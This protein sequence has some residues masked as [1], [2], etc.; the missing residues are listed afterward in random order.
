MV[1]KC[2]QEDWEYL[3]DVYGCDREEVAE[4]IKDKLAENKE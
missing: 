3:F 2:I 1:L 4:E